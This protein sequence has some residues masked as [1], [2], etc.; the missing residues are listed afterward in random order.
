VA[1]SE[2]PEIG[3]E[4]SDA[5]L[6]RRA[7]GGDTAA[8]AA[9]YGRHAPAIHDYL[10]RLLRDRAAAEDITQTAFL[11][12][13]ERL[14]T[15]HE[16]DRARSW[17]FAIAHNLA[18]THLAS[19]RRPAP[20]DDL[21]LAAPGAGPEGAALSAATADLVWTAAASLEPRH[22]A[23]LDLSVRRGFTLDELATAVGS[24]RRHA[25]VMAHRARDAFAAALRALMAVQTATE[26]PRLTQLVP[27]GAPAITAQQRRTAER[28]LRRCAACRSR[29][30]QLTTPAELLGGLVLL[31]LPPSLAGAEW[32]HH[33]LRHAAPPRP[34]PRMSTARRLLSHLGVVAG[35][36]AG[37]A[38]LGGAATAL[39]LAQHHPAPVVSIVRRAEA[40]ATITP[41]AAPASPT[42]TA[43][44]TRPAGVDEAT[45]SPARAFADAADAARSLA[46]YH[47]VFNSTSL[48]T[49]VTFFD[50]HVTRDAYQGTVTLVSAGY[51]QVDVRW[52][53]GV[54]YV[55]GPAIVA[56]PDIFGLTSDEAHTLGNRWLQLRSDGA[57]GDT[58][59]VINDAVGPYVDPT[60]LSE[61]IQPFGALRILNTQDI[62][63]DPVVVLE[64]DTGTLAIT[65][66][67]A[68]PRRAV[69]PPDKFNIDS[70]N[71]S[72]T[73]TPPPGAVTLPRQV[74]S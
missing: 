19:D 21:E 59:A 3:S 33:A 71:D 15:L 23:V 1:E 30:A 37:V 44:P 42:S 69:L 62:G 31:P 29:T 25:S 5:E 74:G 48:S 53:G 26:C 58:A 14:A 28:H 2:L 49:L 54:M 20:L 9:L 61:E 73:V 57:Q 13:W 47:I 32:M 7:Q 8:F 24:T 40:Q 27:A 70:Y 34:A 16:P 64:D 72:V 63:S 12:A 11:R 10:G 35:A 17:L 66:Y 36:V 65:R 39:A 51:A 67:G 60:R 52:T 18:C 4:T 38:G 68:Y 6:V 41:S 46:T 50:L 22:Y 43:I 56:E 45:V 55:S